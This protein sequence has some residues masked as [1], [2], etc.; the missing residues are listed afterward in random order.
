M[1]GSDLEAYRSA[2]TERAIAWFVLAAVLLVL[3]LLLFCLGLSD[4]GGAYFG[5]A[6]IGL[7]GLAL[8]AGVRLL[9]R[10]SHRPTPFSLRGHLRGQL[11]Y[12]AL[13]LVMGVFGLVGA[14][15]WAPRVGPRPGPLR[16][17]QHR[18]CWP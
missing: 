5:G 7:G 6:I 12:A 11:T 13:A 4:D 14:V 8:V 3:G 1:T 17:H 10:R 15:L 16:V 2:Q 9:H 18:C